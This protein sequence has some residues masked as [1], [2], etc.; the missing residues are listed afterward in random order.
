MD[1]VANLDSVL[2]AV[3]ANEIKLDAQLDKNIRQFRGLGDDTERAAAD[4]TAVRAAVAAI[5][6]QLGSLAA[7]GAD[8]RR[9][10]LIRQPKAIRRG[11]EKRTCAT[12]GIDR[13]V[14]RFVVQHEERARLR[15]VAERILPA[16][17][18]GLDRIRGRAVPTS[19]DKRMV[20]DYDLRV[21]H[22]LPSEM[23]PGFQA[24]DAARKAF[25]VAALRQDRFRWRPSACNARGSPS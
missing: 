2:E 10:R 7:A 12:A 13:V 4:L 9:A 6:N 3:L 20:T 16:G 1:T 15:T 19:G 21:Q 8:A 11:L 18:H 5:V 17:E 22:A 23:N 25:Q 24:I 14:K